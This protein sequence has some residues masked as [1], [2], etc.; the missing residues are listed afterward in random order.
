MKIIPLVIIN[1]KLPNF[2]DIPEIKNDARVKVVN[3]IIYPTKQFIMSKIKEELEL[4]EMATVHAVIKDYKKDFDKASPFAAGEELTLEQLVGKYLSDPERCFMPFWTDER[5]HE[6]QGWES[7]NLPE[8]QN[9]TNDSFKPRII[10]KI[11]GTDNTD[12]NNLEKKGEFSN[13]SQLSSSSLSEIDLFEKGDWEKDE[14]TKEDN[15]TEENGT[16]EEVK[17]E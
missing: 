1:A 4:R 11:D 3:P 10:K 5:K 16:E 6:I 12:E 17:E 15:D 9:P 8:S 13:R 14:D 2:E 7:L